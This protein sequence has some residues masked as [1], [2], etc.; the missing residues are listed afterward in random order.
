MAERSESLVSKSCGI[1]SRG[2]GSRARRFGHKARSIV[3]GLTGASIP[4]SRVVHW[5]LVYADLNGQRTLGVAATVVTLHT[6]T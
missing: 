2:F 3:V 1:F 6:Y 5:V 4:L